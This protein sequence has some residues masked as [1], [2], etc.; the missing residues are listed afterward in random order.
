MNEFGYAN[1]KI[2]KLKYKTREIK[3]PD[4]DAVKQWIIEYQLARRSITTYD[5][6]VLALKYED[7]YKKQAKE[8]LTLSKGRGQ[9]GRPLKGQPFQPIDV[10]SKL[11]EIAGA[12]RTAVSE[13]K[14]IQK[15]GTKDIKEKCSK[16]KLPI[17]TAYIH[18][19]DHI[20]NKR[21]NI[22]APP[23]KKFISKNS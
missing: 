23:I 12:G 1:K 3:L 2:H 13:V 11:G 20:R 15:Y 8:N 14:Y 22:E 18:T 9:K 5:K 10:L 4:R 16:G 17:R 7:K 6:I 19:T 21:K